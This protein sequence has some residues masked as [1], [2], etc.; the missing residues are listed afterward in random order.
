MADLQVL[1]NPRLD[2][3][4]YKFPS[5]D[6]QVLELRIWKVQPKL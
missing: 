2:L 4:N 1:D 3:E 6:L 5:L